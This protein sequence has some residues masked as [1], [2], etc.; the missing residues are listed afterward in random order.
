M[1]R[2]EIIKANSDPFVGSQMVYFVNDQGVMEV[3]H[4]EAVVEI[5]PEVL[6]RKIAPFFKKAV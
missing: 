6:A 1:P 3:L 5:A 2:V 4:D